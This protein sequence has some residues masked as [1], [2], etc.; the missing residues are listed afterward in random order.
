ML[1]KYIF[2][3]EKFYK[4]LIKRSLLDKLGYLIKYSN[5]IKWQFLCSLFIYIWKTWG[6]L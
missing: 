2:Q 1:N 6:K 5:K 4:S 3:V